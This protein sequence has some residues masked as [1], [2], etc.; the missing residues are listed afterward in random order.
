M[1]STVISDLM[2]LMVFLLLGF[3]LREVIKPL[4][5]AFIPAGIIGGIMI[6]RK[7]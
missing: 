5:K 4:Q 7:R 1:F 3:V 6:A 2:V